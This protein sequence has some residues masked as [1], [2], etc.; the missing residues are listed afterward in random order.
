MQDL[1][2]G[3]ERALSSGDD[4][5][6]PWSFRFRKTGQSE[7]ISFFSKAL[8]RSEFDFT[9]YYPGEITNPEKQ[10]QFFQALEAGIKDLLEN[11]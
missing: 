10:E 9:A 3:H 7:A 1:R 11:P 8:E 2:E 6:L 5:S 4:F